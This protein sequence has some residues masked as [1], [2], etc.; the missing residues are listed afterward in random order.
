MAPEILIY[1]REAPFYA[2]RLSAAVG[3]ATFRAATRLDEALALA[4]DAVAIAA[5]APEV[6]AELVARAKK[7]R[8]IAA[9]TTGTDHLEAI[10][11]PSDVI[12][13]SMRGIHGPQ[14]AELAFLLMLTLSRDAR[15]MFENQ[16]RHVWRRWPQRLL[17]GKTATLVGVGAIS[18]DLA[19][20]CKAFGMRVIGVSSARQQAKGFDAIY[21]RARL[22]EA[23]AQ[24]DFLVALVPYASETHHMIDARVFAAMKPSAA[25]INVARGLVADERA[26]VDALRDKRIAG[27]GLDVFA[28]EPLAPESPLWDMPNVLI[29]PHIGG[30]SDIYAEQAL[31]ILTENVVAFLDGRFNDMVNRVER[32]QR[33]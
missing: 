16:A 23:A 15:T 32:R 5:L 2:E 26:L 31:P 21:P 30:M 6:P 12:V 24:A 8:W 10:D 29:T 11:L 3:R 27:A 14:M 22:A 9:L 1:E 19:A 17:L 33:S 25:F 4:G 28:H 13:T 18:E 20:R 7:L